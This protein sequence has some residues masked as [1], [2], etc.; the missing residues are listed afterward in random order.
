MTHFLHV[1]NGTS[2]TNTIQ[3]AGLPGRFSIWADVLYDGP[4]PGNLSDAQLLAVRARHLAAD[5]R[6]IPEV[7][8][9]LQGW[10]AVMADPS[11]DELVL[12]Y[13]H[14]LFDQLNLIQ[15]LT[16]IA[17]SD[18]VR[19]EISLICIGSFPG[20]PDFK[21]LGELTPS[22]LAS[23]FETRQR[24]VHAQYALAQR[25]WVAFRASDPRAIEALLHVDTAALPFLAPALRR[26]LQEFPWVGDGLS[27]SER[28]LLHLASS[29][30][31]GIASAFPLMQSGEHAYYI[32]DGSLRQLLEDLASEPSPLIHLDA[33]FSTAILPEGEVTIS[34]TG[35]AVLA[36]D[37]DRVRLRGIDRWFG[38]VH[39][40]GSGPVWRWDDHHKSVG[41]C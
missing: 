4:V 14:D 5:E 36:G 10:R 31:L 2:T 11:Y 32:T 8:A 15:V 33:D 30:P 9:E 27:R 7:V 37:A 38:G 29:G 35:Q 28:R 24:V 40:Q 13:E 12:W 41:L 1:A 20:R 34:Q 18:L 3:Q 22:E 25:A 39:V 21:G 19:R 16:W 6:S 26:Y 23:L 17:G